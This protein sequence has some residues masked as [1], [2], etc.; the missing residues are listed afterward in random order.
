[1]KKLFA[2]TVAALVLGLAVWGS[3]ARQEPAGPALPAPLWALGALQPRLAPDGK[4]IAC[5]YQGA[6][7]RVPVTGGTITCLTEGDGFD[8]EPAWSPDGQTIAFIRGPNQPG[9]ELR[10]VRAADGQEVRLP[11]ALQARGPFNFQKLFYHPDG[12]RILAGQ[13]P[14][15][16]LVLAWLDLETGAVQPLPITLMPFARYALSPDGQWIVYTTTQDRPGEQMG[17]DGPQA[18]LWKMPATGGTATKIL[19]FPARVYDVMWL[20]DNRSLLIVSNL[21]GAYCDL[22]HVPLAD[23]LAGMRKWTFGQADEDRPALSADGKLLVYTDNRGGPTGLVV[24]DLRRGEDQLVRIDRL[25]F[26]RPTGKLRL[27]TLDMEAKTPAVGRVSLVDEAGKYH[28]PPGALYRVLNSMGHFYCDGR[29]ELDVPAGKYRLRAFRGPE[30]RPVS[31]ELTVAPGETLDTAVELSRWAQ[32]ANDGWI[33]GENHIHA[34]YGYGAWFNTPETMLLQCAGEDLR[35]CN[36]MVAN[37]DCD[38]VFDRAFFRGRP[39]TLSTAETTLYWN[40]EFRSTMWGHMTLV[41]LRQVVEPVFTGFV[42][43][44]NPWDIPTNGDVADRTHWQDGLVSYTHAIS[45]ADKPFANPYAAKGLPIDVALGKIDALDLNNSYAGAVPIWYRLLNC[46]FRLPGSAGTDCFLNRIFSRLPGGDRVYV[47]VEGAP[48]YAAWIAGLRAGR[49][50]V[51]NG[52]MLTLSVDGKGLGDVVKLATPGKLRVKA[53][54]RAQLP[55]NKVELVSLGKVIGKLPLAPDSLSATAELDVPAER[56]GWLALR[57][58]GPGQ[59]DFQVP[60]QFA[61]T[62]PV[63]VEIGSSPVRSRADALFFLAWIDDVTALVRTR[64]R[65]PNPALRAEVEK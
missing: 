14:E 6:I 28:A 20:A 30:Y 40:Q 65:I 64:D 31:R 62:S 23:P 1:M 17:N 15:K 49:T 3:G 48:S 47:H 56:S 57:A 7:W 37:S 11:S 21:G 9:G 38:G 39:D 54:V 35:M 50:F 22:W 8:L 5:S 2:S 16:D 43:T 26:R 29:C 36:F 45:D 24:R 58:S 46:G 60:A 61:H 10:L 19:R 34:N 55:L 59:P 44:T 42:A 32:A 52:P 63:Y 25:D 53:T 4:T 13:R 18:D 41:N 12:R 27:R 51:S 33:S